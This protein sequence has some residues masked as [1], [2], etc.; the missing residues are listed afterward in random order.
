M[1]FLQKRWP[2]QEGLPQEKN[3]VQ[4][5]GIYKALLHAWNLPVIPSGLIL[6]PLLVSNVMQE[7]HM[8]QLISGVKHTLE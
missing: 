1:P 6:V 7:L 5:K 8:I 4:E 3:M 2:F